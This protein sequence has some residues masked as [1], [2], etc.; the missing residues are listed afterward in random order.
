MKKKSILLLCALTT[1]GAFAQKSLVDDV[2]HQIG[3]FNVSVDAYKEAAGKIKPAL[4]NAE[5][6]DQAKTW[7]VA[8]KANMGIYDQ[9]MAM[10]QLGKDADKELMATS[11]MTAFNDF[12]VALPLDSVKQTNK[13]GSFK[14]DKKTGLPKIKTE[15]S[16]DIAG[17]LVGH[18]VDFNRVGSDL[19][20]LKKYKEAYDAWGA[21]LEL[22]NMGIAGKDKFNPV[23][24]ADSTMSLIAF[25]RGIAAWQAEDM[26][27]AV[28]SFAQ[29]RKLGYKEKEAFDYAISCYAGLQD[30]EGIVAIAKE[31]LPLFGDKDPQY[32]NVIIN[33]N[34][35]K[36]NLDEALSMVD[37]AI[38]NKPTAALY[39]L[40]GFVL[41]QKKDEDSALDFYKKA[42]EM[43]SENVQAQFNTGRMYMK[44]AVALATEAE[45]LQGSAFTKFKMEKLDPLYQAALPYM[46]KAYELDTTDTQTKRLLGNI[47][48]QLNME[49]E[50]NALG[51]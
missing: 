28:A 17:I 7:F 12:K 29:A 1:F 35:N 24:V 22:P 50:L 20:N 37:A 14:L 25:Y 36:G 33:D 27:A 8:G 18:H 5:T 47:Y 32:M 42:V 39:N 13:D 44:Q 49:N 10:L 30:N 46:K 6:K 3:G 11:L 19:Y 2:E 41:E 9:C 4:E 23:A 45:K 48:Y 16:K 15:Y 43:E 38:A 34:V 21:Y 31:A 40:K 26:K 51:L